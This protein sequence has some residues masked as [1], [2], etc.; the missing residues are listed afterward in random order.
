MP[1]RQG[2]YPAERGPASTTSG[3][4]G[5]GSGRAVPDPTP[6]VLDSASVRGADTVPARS[7]PAGPDR[8]ALGGR[9]GRPGGSRGRRQRGVGRPVG[10]APAGRSR[11]GG[12]RRS[13]RPATRFGA[14]ANRPGPAACACNRIAPRGGWLGEPSSTMCGGHN[15]AVARVKTGVARWDPATPLLRTSTER[16]P[17]R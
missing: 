3:A 10:T 5:H 1:G 7:A 15:L 4:T 13:A 6:A 8:P 11:G 12:R 16:A 17:L 9:L 2:Q 14:A